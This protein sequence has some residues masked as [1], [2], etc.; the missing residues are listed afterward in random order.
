MSSSSACELSSLRENI[1]NGRPA[2]LRCGP[3]ASRRVA[4]TSDTLG[5]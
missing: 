5:T 3:N 1:R 2:A 4:A